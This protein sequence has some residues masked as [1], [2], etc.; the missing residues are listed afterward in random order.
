[1]KV[2]STLK[3]CFWLYS[4]QYLNRQY[5]SYF[6]L[7]LHSMMYERS[8]KMDAEVMSYIQLEVENVQIT[9]YMQSQRYN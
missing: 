9:L 1:M 2:I 8:P 4:P 5:Y 6:E 3:V 7:P